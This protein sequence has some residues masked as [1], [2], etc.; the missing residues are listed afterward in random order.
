[1]RIRTGVFLWFV[2][3]L[4][5]TGCLQKKNIKGDAFVEREVLVD[6]L[7]DIHLAEGVSNDRKFHHRFEADSVDMLG[8]ILQKY[9]VT[10][11]KFDTTMYTY[12]RYPELMDEIY[13]EVLIKLNVMLDE[14]DQETE[15]NR[16][17]GQ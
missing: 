10:R 2:A 8:P 6:M 3:L 11:Q 14:N 7:V 4:I 5:F 13:N 9:G 17:A 1:M 12:S 16:E 15:A